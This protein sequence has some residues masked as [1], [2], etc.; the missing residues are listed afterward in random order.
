MHPKPEVRKW[1]YG[2]ALAGIPLLVA[3]GIVDESTA[4][5]WAA[6]VGAV[7]APSLAL[8]NIT[9]SDDETHNYEPEL[10]DNP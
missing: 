1:I 9:P 7:V 8:A 4:A 5:L 6:L 3:Y 10:E 2:I